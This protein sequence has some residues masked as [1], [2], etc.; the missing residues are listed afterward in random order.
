MTHRASRLALASSTLAALLATSLAALAVDGVVLIDQNRALAGNVTPGDAPGFPV[1][2]SQPGSY[3]LAGNL[4]LGDPNTSAI[5]IRAANVTLDLNGFTIQGPNVC[6][7][8]SDGTVQCSLTGA[9]AGVRAVATAPV[10]SSGITIVNGSIRGMAG[11]AVDLVSAASTVS[12]IAGVTAMGNGFGLFANTSALIQNNVVNTNQGAGVR[13]G[14]ASLVVD[15][16]ISF[17]G[18]VGLLAITNTASI[19]HARNVITA[20]VGGNLSGGVAVAPSAC[21]NNLPCP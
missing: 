11:P 14:G 21:D 3:R 16:S 13:V 2:I 15:N 18:G 12:R 20:N 7:L 9:G 1:V 4:T 6:G 17:N 10:A 5:E 8:A 19:A